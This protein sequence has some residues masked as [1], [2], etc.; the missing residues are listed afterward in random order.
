MYVGDNLGADMSFNPSEISFRDSEHLDAFGRLRVSN[1]TLV[2]ESQFIYNLLPLLYEQIIL[3]TGATVTFDTTNRHAVMTFAST[4][5]GGKAFMQSYSYHRYQPGKSQLISMSFNFVEQVANCLKFVG[6][7]DGV[8]GIEFQNTGATNRFIIYSGTDLGN[9]IANQADWNLDKLDGTG[10]SGIT[11]DITKRQIVIIDF[12]ALNSG[13]VRCGFD[14]GG[15][16][17]YCHEYNHANEVTT[18]FVQS[19]TLPVRCGMTCTGT[20]STTMHYNC[21]S[22]VSEGGMES[23]QTGLEFAKDFSI[24]AVDGVRTHALSLRP[25]TTF[26]GIVN[27]HNIAIIEV[28]LLVTGNYPVEWELCFGQ[29]ISG[30]TTF[31]DVNT[32]YSSMEYNTAGTA[33]GAAAIVA[34]EDYVAASN[35]ATG[36]SSMNITFRYPVTLDAAGAVRLMGTVSLVVTAFGGNSACRGAVKFVE[37]RG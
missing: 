13:R 18:S 9:Q 4:P 22:V 2:F 32:T 23:A 12:Q 15:K 31:N 36:V 17:I 34:D 20:V 27:R 28:N 21:C 5:T 37:N 24:T 14:I 1:P 6:Y 7:S 33:S 8:N 19:P 10:S 25:K 29:A 30:T 11:L 3:N 26:N 35:Q 16:K